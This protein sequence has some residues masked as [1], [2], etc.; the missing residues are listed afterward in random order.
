MEVITQARV[1]CELG[2]AGDVRGV[3]QPGRRNARQ[4]SLLDAQSW[5][6]ALA[7]LGQDVPWQERRANL[8]V[9]GIR[10]PRRS[11]AIIAIGPSLRIETTGECD[12]CQRMDEIVPGLQAALVPFWRGGVLGRVIADGDIAIGDEVRIEQ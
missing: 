11:G 1:T 2:V 9:G 6:D 10:L 7:V 3:F 12:P 4:V 8:L 5:Q